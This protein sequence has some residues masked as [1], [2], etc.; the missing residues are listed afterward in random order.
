ML[1]KRDADNLFVAESRLVGGVEIDGQLCNADTLRYYEALITL[2]RAAIIQ[3]FRPT[4]EGKVV[5][6]I[7]AGEGGFAHQFKT[8]CPNVTYFVGDDPEL[9]LVPRVDLTISLNSFERMTATQIDVCARRAHASGCPFLYSFNN[10]RITDRDAPSTV[11]EILSRYYW[12]REVAVLPADHVSLDDGNGTARARH[13][14]GWRR[15]KTP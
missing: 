9:L 7:G 5:W 11:G 6:E 15:I 12:L 3:G 13:L 8:L 2:H 4:A 14:V 10:E 1:R